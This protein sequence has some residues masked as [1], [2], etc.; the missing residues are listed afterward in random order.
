M[1]V[2]RLFFEPPVPEPRTVRRF[3]VVAGL[4]AVVGG[5]ASV[6]PH[7]IE[8][9]VRH[10]HPLHEHHDLAEVF[11]WRDLTTAGQTTGD[12]S[13]EVPTENLSVVGH[14]PTVVVTT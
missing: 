3:A 7:H 4:I 10:E 2:I 13:V 14:A 5:P 8:T 1:A 6:L 11:G 9:H 12:L